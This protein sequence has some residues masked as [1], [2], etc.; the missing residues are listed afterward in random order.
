MAQGTFYN[1]SNFCVFFT[2]AVLVRPR[3]RTPGTHRA[4]KASALL[5]LLQAGFATRPHC[6]NRLAAGGESQHSFFCNFFH[7]E[8]FNTN[9]TLGWPGH[10]MMLMQ[11]ARDR[12]T[13][14][15][16]RTC[17][18]YS[19]DDSCTVDRLSASARLCHARF[20]CVCV[21]P[22]ATTALA[23]RNLGLVASANPKLI[24]MC[25]AD[26]GTCTHVRA[27]SWRCCCTVLTRLLTD[28]AV[29]AYNAPKLVESAASYSAFSTEGIHSRIT[30]LSRGSR[31]GKGRRRAG[32]FASFFGGSIWCND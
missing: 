4:Q 10:S 24:N 27:R 2:W 25:A 16:R 20:S 15:Q 12:I 18:R 32:T 30:R 23:S 3:P 13:C 31:T 26:R 9:N 11:D 28:S 22:F 29:S 17:V 7:D 21:C 1:R 8:V 14:V 19:D 5:L 6:I